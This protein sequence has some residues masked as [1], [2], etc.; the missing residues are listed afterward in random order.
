MAGTTTTGIDFVIKVNTGTIASPTYTKVA[1]QRGG[2]LKRTTG[3]ADMTTKDSNNWHE[4]KPTIRSWSIDGDGLIIE[5]DTGY[6]AI[7]T[8]WLA[9]EQVQV[10]M[11]TADGHTNTGMATITDF[12]DD[13]PYDAEATYTIALAGSGALVEA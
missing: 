10:Q 1:G 7:K 3:E 5:N 2:S 13:V 9:N 11:V 8:A 6:S 12:S 4:G